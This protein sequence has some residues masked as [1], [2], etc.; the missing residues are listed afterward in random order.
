MNIIV[1]QNAHIYTGSSENP[2]A[3]TLAIVNDKIVALDQAAEP[4]GEAPG[5]V[6]EDLNGATVLP[7]FTDAHIH[8]MWYA[9]GLQELDLRQV[10]S[11]Q[12]LQRQVA[13]R[14]AVTPPGEWIRGRGWDQNQW[15]TESPSGA[16]FP[17]A[18]ALDKVASRHPVVLIAKSGHALVANTMAMRIAGIMSKPTASSLATREADGAPT[19]MFF[20]DGMNLI[21]DAIPDPSLSEVIE[22]Q[23]LAQTHLLAS[24]ITTIHDVD[25]GQ[26]FTAYQTLH[27]QHRL[28]VRVVKYT[29]RETLDHV[30]ALGMQSGYG[31]DMLRYGGVKLFVD[32]ALG[33]R[34][35]AMLKPYEGEPQNLGILTMGPEELQNIAQRAIAGR[36]AL[37]IHAIGDRANAL[38]LDALEA[39]TQGAPHFPNLVASAAR[40]QPGGRNRIEHVQLITPEDQR[41]LA[42]L[43][44]VASM[45]PIHAPHDSVMAE[46]YWGGRVA[47]A[48]AWRS[49]L[50]AGAVLAFG[51]DAPV[52]PFNP[53]LGLYAAI[54]RRQEPRSGDP[55][56][57]LKSGDLRP[58]LEPRSGD[59]RLTLKSGD[60]RLT[61]KEPRSGDPRLT[62][63]SRPTLK[64]WHEEQRLTLEEAIRAYTWG[65][66]YAVAMEDRLGLLAPGYYADLVVLDRTWHRQQNE[67]LDYSPPSP[68]TLLETQIQRTMVGGKWRYRAP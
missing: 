9:L 49:L 12:D 6:I 11:L 16:E 56:L 35:A 41:R 47:H 48:Y 38:T 59:L 27:R 64:G 10:T 5:A 61:L 67:K 40:E 60:P 24:G 1:L 3:H 33:A 4:W 46:R 7:G 42:R 20:E 22:A 54:T 17:T 29:P 28:Q 65:P 51:S 19:G 13:E 57:T 36:V 8:L 15:P 55:R 66:A 44:V 25:G 68:A 2:W 52:E 63:K 34:T 14:V 18:A 31:D 26:A 43:G 21:L 32:G 62:S 50:D 30:L 58:T 23:A 39:A 53:L 45:Q 37:A